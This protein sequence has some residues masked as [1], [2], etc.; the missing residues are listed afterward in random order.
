MFLCI[1]LIACLEQK[2]GSADINCWKREIP[3]VI[4]GDHYALMSLDLGLWRC[5]QTSHLLTLTQSS[6][7]LPQS[8][9]QSLIPRKHFTSGHLRVQKCHPFLGREVALRNYFCCCS[10][11][12]LQGRGNFCKSC[13]L[14]RAS[15]RT[16]AHVAFWCHVGHMASKSWFR[17]LGWRIGGSTLF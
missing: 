15:C 2:C 13:L 4:H 6:H 9:S 8:V 17:R 14:C 7:L 11:A 10:L 5:F 3:G 12:F 1:S 16:V